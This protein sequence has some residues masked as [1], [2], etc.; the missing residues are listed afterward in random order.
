M[1]DQVNHEM[2][3]IILSCAEEKKAAIIDFPEW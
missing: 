1:K 3:F 2:W